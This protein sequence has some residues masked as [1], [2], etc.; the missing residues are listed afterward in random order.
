MA[1]D[2][3][4]MLAAIHAVQHFHRVGHQS[5][6]RRPGKAGYASGELETEA[7]NIRMNADTL[8]KARAFA[9]PVTGYSTS[10]LKKFCQAIRLNWTNFIRR[11]SAVG[12]T[13]VILLMS[14]PKAQGVRARVQAKMFRGG[15]STSLLQVELRR[16]FGRRRQGGRKADVGSTV[17]EVLMRIDVQRETWLRMYSE[18]ERRDKE[19][20]SA[21]LKELPPAYRSA[22][23]RITH[24]LR[25]IGIEV[26][27]NLK[28]DDRK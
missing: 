9:H 12:P 3:E 16:L 11:K 14:V 18:L 22:I 7:A 21:G 23:S 19:G 13:H 17:A 8:R 10:E 20:T 24:E 6:I 5:L 26:A 28:R 2:R 27:G 15:W 4:R 1:T 25:R